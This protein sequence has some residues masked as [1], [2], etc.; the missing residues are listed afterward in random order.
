MIELRPTPFSKRHIALA[1]VQR[2][3]HFVGAGLLV[4]R[5]GGN[6]Y[7]WLYLLCQGTEVF[8]KGVLL[9]KDYDYYEPRLKK[10]FGHNVVK[11]AAEAAQAFEVAA[12]AGALLEELTQLNTYYSQHLLRYASGLDL[13]VDPSTISY[14]RVLRRFYA[15]SRLA[16]KPV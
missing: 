14:V 16:S 4:K 1:M 10:K 2:G 12:P 7:V 11:L 3:Q 15:A 8:L 6:G 9:L 13:L 5:Q